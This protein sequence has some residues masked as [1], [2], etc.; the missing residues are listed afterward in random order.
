VNSHAPCCHMATLRAWLFR[1][2]QP[3][4]R[5]V[6][7]RVDNAA[8]V[9]GPVTGLLGRAHRQSGPRSHNAPGV[10]VPALACSTWRYSPVAAFADYI[11][12]AARGALAEN[13][14]DEA[15]GKS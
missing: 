2:I 14:N 13:K 5:A 12:H 1:W 7:S 15:I 10:A 8:H 6:R 11:R 9:G 4:I 3:R